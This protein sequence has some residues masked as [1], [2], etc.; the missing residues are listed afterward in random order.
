MLFGKTV[1]VTGVAS[2]IGVDVRAPAS[3]MRNFVAADL[4]SQAAIDAL[5]AS[6]SGRFDAL[7]NVAGVSGTPGIAP[8]RWPSTSTG[9]GR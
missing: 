2:S 3:P 1:V 6:L 8:I 9:C 4:S 7:C 5:T